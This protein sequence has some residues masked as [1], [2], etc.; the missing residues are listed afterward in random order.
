MLTDSSIMYIQLSIYYVAY[1]KLSLHVHYTSIKKLDF[2]KLKISRK[3][4]RISKLNILYITH[5]SN[6]KFHG[7]LENTL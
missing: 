7:K 1:L 5:M 3:V 2:K 6:R 4:L